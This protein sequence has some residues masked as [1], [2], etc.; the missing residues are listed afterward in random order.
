VTGDGV[1]HL[2]QTR[3]QIGQGGPAGD[4][5][6]FRFA[7]D[8][9]GE[10]AAD[11]ANLGVH[12]TREVEPGEK[13]LLAVDRGQPVT[14]LASDFLRTNGLSEDLLVG[15]QAFAA[16]NQGES[17]LQLLRALGNRRPTLWIGQAAVELI[18]SLPPEIDEAQRAA[19]RNRFTRRPRP[20]KASVN[21]G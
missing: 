21:G 3:V 16:A 17:A 4:H 5:V 7:L 13:G 12:Q 8:R 11:V 6:G 18:D 10:P 2:L 14:E 20:V 19:L 9:R 1:E 15:A